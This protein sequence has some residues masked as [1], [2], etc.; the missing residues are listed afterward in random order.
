MA[1]RQTEQSNENKVKVDW[2][3]INRKVNS[4]EESLNN[5]SNISPEEKRSVLKKRAKALAVEKTEELARNEYIDIVKFSLASEIYGIE[6]RYIREV[7]SLIDFTVLPGVPP[8]V[9]G[10][11]NVRGQ[12]ISVIDL[13]KFFN[14]PEKGIGE[15]NKV[16]IINNER[17][18]FGILADIVHGSFSIAIHDIQTI[19]DP[20]S[21]IGAGYLRGVT[22]DHSIILDA[23]TI[24][25]D[26][27]IVIHQ[28]A[29]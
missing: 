27:G 11:I 28:K 4:L 16:I 6:K 15:L 7:H 20:S 5:L 18:E 13:K 24:L 14:L 8:F 19:P 2:I 29:E 26:K 25:A 10:I 17:I 23:E 9:L 1:N 12:I 22:N 21:G 3:E